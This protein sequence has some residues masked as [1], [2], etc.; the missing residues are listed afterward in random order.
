MLPIS[1]VADS[2]RDNSRSPVPNETFS[3]R[4]ENRLGR[5]DFGSS[6]VNLIILLACIK[7]NVVSVLAY[8]FI[9]EKDSAI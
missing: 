2:N 5:N 4:I 1:G 7:F 3:T 6:F 9:I 8:Q